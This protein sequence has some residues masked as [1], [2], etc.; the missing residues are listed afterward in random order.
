MYPGAKVPHLGDLGVEK[1]RRLYEQRLS[2][3][4]LIFENHNFDKNLLT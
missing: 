2:P 4:T 1:S 3:L